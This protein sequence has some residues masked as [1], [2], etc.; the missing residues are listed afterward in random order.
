LPTV[1]VKA[2]KLYLAPK[3]CIEKKKKKSGGGGGERVPV[4]ETN[5]TRIHEDAGSIPGLTQWVKDPA[6]P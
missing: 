6:L 1:C 3:S 5:V 2:Q 4:V